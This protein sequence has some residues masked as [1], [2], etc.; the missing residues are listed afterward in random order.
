[1]A[2]LGILG[3]YQAARYTARQLGHR[4]RESLHISP[5]LDSY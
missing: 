4:D 3:I 1:M 2:V 5:K